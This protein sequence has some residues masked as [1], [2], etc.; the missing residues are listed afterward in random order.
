LLNV[1]V[2]VTLAELD[3]VRRLHERGDRKVRVGQAGP[4]V[5]ADEPVR[6]V[7][8]RRGDGV[9]DRVHDAGRREE[10]PVDDEDSE[11]RFVDAC[12]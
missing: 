8:D 7:T 11:L 5:H 1:A 9:R 12:R 3:Q 6:E 4:V 2:Y 10:D